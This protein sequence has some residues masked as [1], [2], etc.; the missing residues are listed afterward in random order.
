[1]HTRNR[2]VITD[3]L[4]SPISQH[5]VCSEISIS[6]LTQFEQSGWWCTM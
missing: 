2:C 1:M 4:L 5:S 3:L 6:K